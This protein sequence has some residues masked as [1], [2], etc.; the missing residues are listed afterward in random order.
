MLGG[1]LAD[2][3]ERPEAESPEGVLGPTRSWKRGRDV[4]EMLIRGRASVACP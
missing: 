4:I 2:Q 3:D 1:I